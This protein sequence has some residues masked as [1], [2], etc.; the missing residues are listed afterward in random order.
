MLD[1]ADGMRVL[2]ACAAPGGKTGHLLELAELDLL[3]L[4]SDANRLQRVQENLDRLGLAHKPGVKLLAED[5]AKPS[6][7]WDKMPSTAFCSMRHAPLPVSCVGILT[8]NG[9]NARKICNIW[10]A[11][12]PGCWKLYGRC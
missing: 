3:A 11:N 12:R 8:A 7:W 10:R 6:L 4:D 9:S 5:A 1:V 2:D